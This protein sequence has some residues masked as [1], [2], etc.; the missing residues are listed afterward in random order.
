LKIPRTNVVST[1]VKSVGYDTP[2]RTLDVEFATGVYRYDDV[3]QDVF[4]RMMNAESIGKFIH[5]DI[6]NA[7]TGVKQV[8]A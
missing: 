3:P 7:F 8:A 6:K 1:N 5:T 2:T 4:D